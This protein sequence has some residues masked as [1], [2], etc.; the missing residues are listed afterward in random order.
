MLRRGRRSLLTLIGIAIGVC[1]VVVINS[2]GTSGAQTVSAELQSM[3][4]GG[5]LIAHEDKSVVLS[6]KEIRVLRQS[7][8]VDYVMPVNI[9]AATCEINNIKSGNALLFGVDEG[10]GNVVSMKI[11]SGRTLTARDLTEQA[12]VCV[13]DEAILSRLNPK[14]DPIG[15][16]ITLSADGHDC[17]FEI[18]GIMESNAGFIQNMLGEYAPAFVYVP[19]TTLQSATGTPENQ[20]VVVKMNGIK[21]ED[22][23]PYLNALM[24]KYSGGT[25]AYTIDSLTQQQDSLYSVME[26]V[27]TILTLIGS[28]SLLVA[29]LNIMTT[30]LV[31]VQERTREIGI[32]KSIGAGNGVILQEFLLE[33]IVLS[34]TGSL[35]GIGIGWLLIRVFAG[36]QVSVWN[37]MM[38]GGITTICGGIFGVYPAYRAAVMQP[39]DALKAD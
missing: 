21:D 1:S 35:L 10:V 29:C 26:L 3:G 12:A 24:N 38:I 13:A 17:E 15:Q 5:V 36:L 28:I 32:K 25:Y 7:G 8:L 30:M 20:Q 18:V 22:I 6:S 4:L 16:K 39:I 14:Q 9:L 11:L 2:I 37:C 31:A 34:A 19:Y 27:T 33:A 23:K